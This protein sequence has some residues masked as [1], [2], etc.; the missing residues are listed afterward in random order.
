MPDA[1]AGTPPG[2]PGPGG[3]LGAPGAGLSRRRFLGMAGAGVAAAVPV[4][5]LLSGCSSASANDNLKVGVIAPL[6]GPDAATGTVVTNSLQASIHHLNATGGLGGRKVE[7]LLRDAGA[8]A[9]GGQRLYPQLAGTPGVAAILW[10][11]ALG[12]DA[13]LPAIRR[14]AMPVVTAFEDLYSSGR[15]YPQSRSGGPSVFQL[16]PPDAYLQAA[17]ASYAGSDRGYTSA[18][19]LYDRTLDPSGVVSGVFHDAFAK[20]G[21]T[22]VLA[23]SFTTGQKDLSPQLGRLRAAVPQV[24]YFDGLPA[25]LATAA[26]GLATMKAPFVDKPTDLAR[27]WHPQVFGS[28]RAMGDGTWA[29][30]AG[31][32]ARVGSVTATHLGGLPYLPSFTI[33]RWMERYLGAEPTGNEDLPADALMAVLAGVKQAGSTDRRK[34]AAAIQGLD[35]V[36]FASVPFGFAGRHLARTP[37]DTAIMTLEYL[38]GPAPT[39]PPYQLGKEWSTGQLYAATPA[40]PTQLVRP[41]LAANRRAHPHAMATVMAQGWGTQCTKLPDGSLSKVCKIH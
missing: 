41:T 29:T 13:V 11:G 1:A 23:D 36:T 2:R 12:L 31:D 33:R 5:G 37:D 39:N 21:V 17:L 40:G 38:R 27:P 18:A 32:A 6:S 3:G 20:A 28:L 16:S 8:Q 9:Q 34:V 25:D 30:S 4:A 14:D 7:L 22:P 19:L 35:K 24:V 26:E 15:L 10:C